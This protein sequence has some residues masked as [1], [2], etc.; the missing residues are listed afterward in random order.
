[1]SCL[2]EVL[3]QGWIKNKKPPLP[4]TRARLA[5]TD[6]PVGP[7]LAT[8]LLCWFSAETTLHHHWKATLHRAWHTL[9]LSKQRGEKEN[10]HAS[11][12]RVTCGLLTTAIPGNSLHV[13]QHRTTRK[14]SS[15]PSALLLP[16]PKPGPSQKHRTVTLT[17]LR[18]G[19][20]RKW[21]P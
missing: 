7:E 18:R 3:P 12:T 20:I 15:L 14:R 1:M 19:G 11:S 13:P 9:L 5:G 10:K 2:E 21:Q 17:S 8:A 4:I 6:T 16:S